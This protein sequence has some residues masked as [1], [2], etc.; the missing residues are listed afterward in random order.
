VEVTGVGAGVGA[1]AA[2]VCSST[3]QQVSNAVH[4][5]MN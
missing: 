1:A 2:E 3:I 4:G 5:K